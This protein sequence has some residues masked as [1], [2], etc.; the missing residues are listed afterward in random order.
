MPTKIGMLAFVT[1]ALAS[2]PALAQSCGSP[3]IAPA[4]PSVAEINQKTPADAATT[5]HDGFIEIKNWQ[6]DLKTYRACVTHLSADDKKQ[7]R[8]TDP[9]KDADKIK[10]LQD[11]AAAADHNYDATVDMEERVANEFHAI[12]AAYCARPDTDKSSCP[13]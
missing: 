11:E 2:A 5:K 12:Q 8:E 4:L 9:K 7:L 3:P 1:A 6:A 10:R 13:K